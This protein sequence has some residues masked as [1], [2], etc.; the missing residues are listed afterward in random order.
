MYQRTPPLYCFSS[1]KQE[2]NARYSNTRGVL[3]IKVSVGLRIR[4][5]L[6]CTDNPMGPRAADIHK[7]GMKKEKALLWEALLWIGVVPEFR[8]PLT[9]GDVFPLE[10]CHTDPDSI[11]VI[12][13]LEFDP[14]I[15]PQIKVSI[16]LCSGPAE[17]LSSCGDLALIV[18]EVLG[19]GG[20][21]DGFG[22]CNGTVGNTG[23]GIFPEIYDPWEGKK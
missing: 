18:Q 19:I 17:D 3:E 16:G 21:E 4:A 9:V 14:E 6:I 13:I 10:P 8:Y 2:Q 5:F 7:R 23:L 22:F 12:L 15:R 11:L 1:K 20:I